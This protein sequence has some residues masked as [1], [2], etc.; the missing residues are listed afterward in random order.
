MW[1]TPKLLSG[2]TKTLP[3][4]S[5]FAQGKA[6]RD[7][8]GIHTNVFTNEGQEGGV[9]VYLLSITP[10]CYFSTLKYRR[11]GEYIDVFNGAW[12]HLL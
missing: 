7:Q 8:H 3:G 12:Y 5:I 4:F 2:S 11:L 10:A 9:T 6:Q 1:K